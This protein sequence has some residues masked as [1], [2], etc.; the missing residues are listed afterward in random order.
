[1]KRAE[2]MKEIR[3]AEREK[4]RAALSELKREL[5]AARIALRGQM[6]L[7]RRRCIEERKRLRLRLKDRREKLLAELRLNAAAEK[8]SAR[9]ECD[10]GIAA[11][12]ELKTQAQQRRAVLDAEK[13]YRADLRR[14]EAGNRERVRQAKHRATSAERRAESD[15]A[16]RANL[17]PHLL[18]LFQRVKGT[19]RGGPRMSRT[20]AFLKYA[21]EHPNEY[22]EAI[23]DRTDAL[24]RELE[25]RWAAAS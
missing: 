16:V 21:E 8:L 2:L 1:M 22:L 11:A 3:R 12:R 20:E 19:I 25:A 5:D 10:T 6:G 24:V 23:E 14:I 4:Q 17:P 9:Q 18:A 15:E 7:A 13:K